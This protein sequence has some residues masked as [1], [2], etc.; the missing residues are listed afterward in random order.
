MSLAFL[1]V[2]PH[3][4]HVVGYRRAQLRP[5][6]SVSSTP[7]YRGFCPREYARDG[8]IGLMNLSYWIVLGG[9]T[10]IAL[11]LLLGILGYRADYLVVLGNMVT[12]AVGFLLLTG[13]FII[14]PSY[15]LFKKNNERRQRILAGLLLAF[16]VVASVGTVWFVYDCA[17][18]GKATWVHPFYKVIEGD[19]R[20]ECKSLMNPF[21]RSE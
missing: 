12:G 13:I 10:I 16:G 15:Q 19:E 21:N 3:L 6:S 8:T 7:L 17:Q 5:S 2:R 14:F 9:V 4:L 18:E 1:E 11:H 20:L